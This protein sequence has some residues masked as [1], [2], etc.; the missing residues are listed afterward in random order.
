MESYEIS[1]TDYLSDDNPDL[2][3]KVKDHVLD[4]KPEHDDGSSKSLP[5]CKKCG[6]EAVQK[7]NLLWICPQIYD[8]P[9]K[10]LHPG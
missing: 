9:D 1:H 5:K 7:M 2:W 3:E 8:V 10:Y 4:W 6:C